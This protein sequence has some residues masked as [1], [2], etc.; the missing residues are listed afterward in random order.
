MTISIQTKFYIFLCK[1]HKQFTKAVDVLVYEARFKCC[2]TVQWLSGRLIKYFS[3]PTLLHRYT[4]TPGYIDFTVLLRSFLSLRTLLVLKL[5]VFCFI[6][7]VVCLISQSVPW[8]SIFGLELLL[9]LLTTWLEVSAKKESFTLNESQPGY[10]CI[11]LY[12]K[13]GLISIHEDPGAFSG[14]KRKLKRQG[15]ILAEK[16]RKA[17]E[18]PLGMES[19]STISKPLNK[20]VASKLGKKIPCIVLPNLQWQVHSPFCVFL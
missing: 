6:S 5:L 12:C 20:H 4:I 17:S 15:K 14:G 11:F 9:S 10:L 7:F 18:E 16:S 13:L 19:Y 8:F 2:H 1:M 3:V